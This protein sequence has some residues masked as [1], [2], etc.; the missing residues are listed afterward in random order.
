[1]NPTTELNVGSEI[2]ELARTRW[3]EHTRLCGE[4]A[5]LPTW[6]KLDSFHKGG[7]LDHSERIFLK[8]ALES[9]AGS[10]SAAAKTLHD[11]SCPDNAER[12]EEAAERAERI[13]K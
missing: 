12:A 7:W 2:A 11:A 1:M 5:N 3:E 9:A 4:G 8:R 10:L 6:E 13:A